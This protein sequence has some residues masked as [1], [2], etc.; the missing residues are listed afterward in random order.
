MSITKN[1]SNQ[2]VYTV[3]PTQ[4]RDKASGTVVDENFSIVDNQN[5]LKQIQFRI[6]PTDTNPGILTFTASIGAD[7]TV[8]L[9]SGGGGADV[10]IT[11]V[12]YVSKGGN[13]S[14]AAISSLT[15]PCLTVTKALT[16]VSGA[17][18]SN[19]YLIDVGPGLFTESNLVIGAW[20]WLRGCTSTALGLS[21]TTGATATRIAGNLS[22]STTFGNNAAGGI[23]DITLINLTCD[24]SLASGTSRKYNVTNVGITGTSIA[25]GKSLSDEISLDRVVMSQAATLSQATF[26]VKSCSSAVS[27]DFLTNDT[28]DVSGEVTLSRAPALTLT[29]GA[30][31]ATMSSFGNQFDSVTLADASCIL[32]SDSISIP[33]GDVVLN[34]GSLN[35]ATT[36]VSLGYT[37]NNPT[38]WSGSPITVQEAIDRIASVV[39][40]VTPIP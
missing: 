12:I 28:S 21:S 15:H 8:D 18:S 25:T 19:K 20:T 38:K 6:T 2:I 17:S 29:A 26:I 4:E 32:T 35:Y 14:T 9:T 13:D 31:N 1:G 27:I 36:S 24:L 16:L 34:G 33:A 37:P 30:N 5:V 40:N 22:V 39:G 3:S 10:G 11:R 23:S 7:A